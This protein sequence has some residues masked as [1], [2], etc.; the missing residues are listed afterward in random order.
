M[1]SKF[2]RF[3]TLKK[4][5]KALKNKSR[6]ILTFSTVFK[7]QKM[8]KLRWNID[9]DISTPFQRGFFFLTRDITEKEVRPALET[10]RNVKATG[11]TFYVIH[12]DVWSGRVGDGI[13]MLWKLTR[14]I[15]DLEEIV[16]RGDTKE[17]Q[18][19]SDYSNL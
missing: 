15:Y 3:L 17:V 7:C 14:K 8:L 16:D 4:R 10:T 11:R 12:V 9:V 1:T 13:H 19:Q 6:G 18:R 5:R 2:Q